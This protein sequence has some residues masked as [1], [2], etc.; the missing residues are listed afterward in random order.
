MKNV[1]VHLQ[2]LLA[3]WK[4]FWVLPITAPLW[5]T[6]ARPGLS[7][8]RVI[9]YCYCSMRTNHFIT[10]VTIAMYVLYYGVPTP[11]LISVINSRY[12][13]LKCY[14]CFLVCDLVLTILTLEVMR[15]T[16]C[17]ASNDLIDFSILHTDTIILAWG[18][19]TAHP[20]I[21]C[22]QWTH[23]DIV[24]VYQEGRILSY[25]YGFCST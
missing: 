25:T 9:F 14:A 7:W 22:I 23:V 15:V 11:L 8:R 5:Y 21:V 13:S 17:I 1:R 12:Y 24:H 10:F 18:R 2:H 16:I 6:Q 4:P 3:L 20:V 19:H